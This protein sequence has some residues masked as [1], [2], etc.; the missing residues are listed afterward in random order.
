MELFESDEQWIEDDLRQQSC[1]QFEEQRDHGEGNRGS[2]VPGRVVKMI[3]ID[4]AA[5]G[6][7]GAA[8]SLWERDG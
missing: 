7:Q 1:G 4:D 6:A 3:K 2:E 8:W 5:P